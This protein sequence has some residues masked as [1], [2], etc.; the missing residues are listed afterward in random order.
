MTNSV[1]NTPAG[2]PDGEPVPTLT[3]EDE[4]PVVVTDD[5]K[6]LAVAF[7][8][9]RVGVAFD[10]FDGTGTSRTGSPDSLHF[11]QA[12]GIERLWSVHRV[13]EVVPGDEFTDELR[14]VLEV[15]RVGVHEFEVKFRLAGI[16]IGEQTDPVGQPVAGVARSVFRDVDSEVV[17]RFSGVRFQSI[18][19]KTNT[20]V[21]LRVRVRSGKREARRVP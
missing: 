19:V 11:E 5:A 10:G 6:R 16:D 1:G 18:R 2:R 21:D 7:P 15:C 9:R 4:H 8:V 13:V 12:V 17:K 20:T 14:R 3:H